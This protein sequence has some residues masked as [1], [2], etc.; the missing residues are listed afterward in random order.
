MVVHALLSF[1]VQRSVGENEGADRIKGVVFMYILY[2]L[3]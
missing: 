2:A 1:Y 3:H